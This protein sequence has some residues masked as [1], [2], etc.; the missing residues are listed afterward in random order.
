[1]NYLIAGLFILALI[2]TI[3][4]YFTAKVCKKLQEENTQIK[5]ELEEQ[6]LTI[7]ELYKNAEEI[8]RIQKDKSDINKK[9]NEA[10]SDEE[11]C[12]IISAIVHTNN[13]KLRK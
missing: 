13:D 6:K 12:A 4:A 11:I 2:T 3:A 9:I 5:T 7:K 10:E 1:M 8:A